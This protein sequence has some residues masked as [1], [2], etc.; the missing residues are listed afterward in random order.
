MKKR[1]RGFILALVVSFLTGCGGASKDVML[2]P[3]KELPSWY[4]NPP[5]ST[6]TTLY[7]LGEGKDKQEAITN[8]LNYLASTLSVSIESTYNAKTVVKEGRVEENNAEYRS[9][10]TSEVQKI[11]IG[12]YQVVQA[13]QLGF[14][15]YAVLIESNKQRLLQSLKQELEQTMQIYRAMEQDLRSDDALSHYIFYKKARQKLQNLPRTLLIMQELESSFDANRYLEKVKYVNEKYS[16]YKNNIT[17]LVRSNIDNMDAPLAKAITQQGFRIRNLPN[18]MHYTVHVSTSVSKAKA[19]GF[20]LARAEVHIKT[21]N[22]KGVVVASN[23]L[24]LVGQSTQGYNVA[25]QDLVRKFDQK[26]QQ[27]GLAKVLNLDI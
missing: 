25:M 18:K 22:Y 1:Y 12:N 13:K 6:A 15:R 24:N 5:Q 27:D 2:E 7:A 21:K 14:K 26:I 8:A 20:T 10:V 16:Y 23:V 4:T 9:D 11:R 17:F 19:Y 3:K